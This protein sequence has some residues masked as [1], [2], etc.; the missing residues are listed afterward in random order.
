MLRL[1]KLLRQEQAEHLSGLREE[2][3]LLMAEGR[4]LVHKCQVTRVPV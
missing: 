3:F 1:V 4:T 2:E